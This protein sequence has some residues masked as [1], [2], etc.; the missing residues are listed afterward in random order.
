MKSENDIKK[1]I[2]NR[3]YQIDDASRDR[4]LAGALAELD[5][6]RAAGDG[7]ST[8]FFI[9]MLRNRSV[10]LAAVASVIFAIIVGAELFESPV[11]IC[12]LAVAEVN[13][14]LEHSNDFTYR[15]QQQIFYGGDE[16]SGPTETVLY[17][18]GDYGI[19][20]G[21]YSNGKATERTFVLPAEKVMITVMPEDKQYKRN[22]L[23][24]QTV[25]QVQEEKDPREL[26]RQFLSSNYRDLGCANIGGVEARGIEVRNPAFLLNSM[27]DVVGRLWVNSKTQLPVR[28]EIEGIDK[29]IMKRVQIVTDEFR[30][31]AKFQ[32][33]QFGPF[34]PE[35]YVLEK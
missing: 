35:D 25:K 16:Y 24:E 27:E 5:K 30:W 14:N 2:K 31:G 8:N 15:H 20:F 13:E 29:S 32:K 11:S 12:S 33:E 1:L 17:V 3:E 18:S 28:M 6:R 22:E 9:S 21:T 23:S 4:I 26:I 19:R 34:I 7:K 10:Q